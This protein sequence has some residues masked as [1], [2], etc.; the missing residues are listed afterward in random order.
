[1]SRKVYDRVK[2]TATTTGTG[3][4]TLAGAVSGFVSFDTALDDADTTYYCIQHQSAD[5]W[6]VGEGTFTAS[7][8]TLARTTVLRSS[9]S[10]SAVNFSAGTKDVFITQPAKRTPLWDVDSDTAFDNYGVQRIRHS[11]EN[12]LTN[13]SFE[14]WNSGT[15]VAPD[16]WT[17]A[18]DATIAR[19]AAESWALGS[20]TAKITF[21]T[22]N[23]G[24]LYQVIGT[25]TLVDYTFSCY[26]ERTSG[27]GAARL[28]AQRADSPFTEFASVTLPTD[29]G[30][31]P[32]ALT[33][34]P[35]A[36][37]Q[38]RFAIK[39]GDTTASTWAI[40][41]CMYQ[42]SRGIATTHQPR[43]LNDTYD[44][45]FYANYYFWGILQSGGNAVST[46]DETVTYVNHGATAGTARP[47]GFDMVIWTRIVT[48]KQ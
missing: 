23:T 1:M 33:F 37:T 20:Y 39:S 6:E 3:T 2:E 11:T 41:E 15:S 22:A 19:S 32:V 14:F 17:L 43:F 25:S 8:T 34:K 5:E 45:N 31:N 40:D 46:Q 13:S 27:T 44:G 24:E 42:E 4:F 36:G 26:V 28:V 48:G 38:T 16:S 7:G 12:F 10:D 35:S 47:T 18:G 30:Q 9:N 21:G 29:A